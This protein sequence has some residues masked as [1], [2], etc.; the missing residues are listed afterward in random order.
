MSQKSDTTTHD[1]TETRCAECEEPIPSRTE[2][3]GQ[4]AHVDCD[5]PERGTVGK[6]EG[7]TPSGLVL[8]L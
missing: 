5:A 1:T 2:D 3:P 7:Y 8:A 6:Q 4:R